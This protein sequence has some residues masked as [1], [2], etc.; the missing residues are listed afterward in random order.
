MRRALT[1]GGSVI[2]IAL[3]NAIPVLADPPTSLGTNPHQQAVN[4]EIH[5]GQCEG[6]YAA[7]V[8]HNGIVVRDQ[9]HSPMGK[10]AF[11]DLAH[12]CTT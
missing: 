5:S 12:A 2:A 10:E 9:A 6:L 1:V 11:V 8:T 7:Q 4:S 3:T